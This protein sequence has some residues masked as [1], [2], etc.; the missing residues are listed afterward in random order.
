MMHSGTIALIVAAVAVL[1]QIGHT[2]TVAEIVRAW[3]LLGA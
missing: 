2:E 3:G 1:P